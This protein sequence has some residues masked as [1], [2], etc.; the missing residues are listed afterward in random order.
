MK[1]CAFTKSVS[2]SIVC[3]K[4]S[5]DGVLFQVDFSVWIHAHYCALAKDSVQNY[6]HE[7]NALEK[8]QTWWIRAIDR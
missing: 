1:I 7:H 6:K 4:E 3:W 8:L 2:Q 5:T